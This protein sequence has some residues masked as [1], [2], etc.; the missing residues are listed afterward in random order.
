TP[1]PDPKPTAAQ[2]DPAPPGASGLPTHHPIFG[3]DSRISSLSRQLGWDRRVNVGFLW[4]DQ[5]PSP[6]ASRQSSHGCLSHAG[7]PS[8]SGLLGEVP[9][10]R[11]HRRP[12]RPEVLAMSLAV[13]PSDFMRF[14]V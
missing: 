1:P 10:H 5:K 6:G 9:L 13:C 8:G 11:L 4:S 2:H 12:A 14:A 3:S 7:S